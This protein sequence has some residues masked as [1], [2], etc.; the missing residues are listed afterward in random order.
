MLYEA[1]IR[2]LA[3]AEVHI[4]QKD[5]DVANNCL[6]RAQEIVYELMAS[7]DAQA[8]DGGE[9]LMGLYAWM[10]SELIDANVQKNASKIQAVR[11]LVE[12]LAQ[13]WREAI[14]LAAQ[15][16][17]NKEHAPADMVV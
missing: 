16:A 11:Q 2:N 5:L 15:E 7:L 3:Q 9:Q 8:F 6:I 17:P 13:T 10:Q 4:E 1:L 14:D 12:P